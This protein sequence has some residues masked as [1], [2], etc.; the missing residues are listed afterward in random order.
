MTGKENEILPTFTLAIPFS[1][2]KQACGPEARALRGKS[3]GGK[4]NPLEDPFVLPQNGAGPSGA[5]PSVPTSES[6]GSW[7]KNG[8]PAR[9]KKRG[10]PHDFFAKCPCFRAGQRL[11]FNRLWAYLA[12][13]GAGQGMKCGVRNSE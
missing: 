8:L 7:R 11:K 2:Q 3:I 13:S 4:K 10:A 12:K 9:P 6:A 5:R 1:A